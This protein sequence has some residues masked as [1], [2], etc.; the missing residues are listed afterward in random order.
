MVEDGLPI[1][2]RVNRTKG[3]FTGLPLDNLLKY[4]TLVSCFVYYPILIS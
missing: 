3:T 4:T 2:D 1:A